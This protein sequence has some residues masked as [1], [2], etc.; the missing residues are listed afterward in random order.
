MIKKKKKKVGWAD[1]NPY[2]KNDY[3][4]SCNLQKDLFL[5]KDIKI[6]NNHLRMRPG[7]S[8]IKNK[9]KSVPP[10]REY[11]TLKDNINNKNMKMMNL[12]KALKK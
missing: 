4:F 5:M 10:E 12:M 1:N 11:I 6:V 8:C 3:L 2:G 7:K 9:S